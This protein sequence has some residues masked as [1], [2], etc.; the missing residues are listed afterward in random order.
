MSTESLLATLPT[1][2]RLALAYAPG[3]AREPTLAL[4]AL[5]ARL[6]G[7]VRS[8]REPMLAQLRLAWWREQLRVPVARWPEGEP[9]LAALRSWDAERDALAALADG[10]EAL[11]GAAPLPAAAME[12]LARARGQAFA[13]LARLLGVEREAA[14]AERLGIDW[15]LADIAARL[16]STKERQTAVALA[17]ARDWRPAPL[18]RTLRPL[19]VL[20]GLARRAVLRGETLDTLPPGAL[21]SVLRVGLLGR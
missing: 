11:T 2:Q 19:A 12:Q 15:A 9:L 3:S 17:K 6:A 20:R 13:A 16:G 18:S 8:A 21:A 4:L 14:A 7:V 1:L 10:F 5:D